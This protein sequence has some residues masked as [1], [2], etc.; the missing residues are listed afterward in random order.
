MIYRFIFIERGVN[1]HGV[2]LFQGQRCLFIALN[3]KTEELLLESSHIRYIEKKM[4]ASSP[5]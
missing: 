5:A 1:E 2:Y 3:K 4:L